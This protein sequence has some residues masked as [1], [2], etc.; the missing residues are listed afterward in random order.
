MTQA[1]YAE[2]LAGVS[3]PDSTKV[4]NETLILNGLGLREKYWVDIYVADFISPG[5]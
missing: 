5:K 1:I 4:N 2:N 3:M